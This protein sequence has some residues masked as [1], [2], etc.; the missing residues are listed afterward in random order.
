[1]IQ[2]ADGLPVLRAIESINAKLGLASGVLLQNLCTCCMIA[3]AAARKAALLGS[4]PHQL[5]LLCLQVSVIY[6]PTVIATIIVPQQYCGAVM[7]L[8]VQRRG[9]QLEYSFLGGSSSAF[10]RDVV[11]SAETLG[12]CQTQ[13]DTPMSFAA[14]AADTGAGSAPAVADSSLSGSDRVLL[15]YQLPLS[16]LAGDFY[17]KLKSVTQG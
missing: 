7:K 1:M 5:L 10:K 3:D 8:A 15:R 11:Q 12:S 13:M 14:A 9:D 6:E 2:V 16:E 4:K 17:N